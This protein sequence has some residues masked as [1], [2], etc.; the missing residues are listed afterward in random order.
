[1]KE[2]LFAGDVPSKVENASYQ[3]KG[4]VRRELRP[5]HARLVRT[6]SPQLLSH[7]GHARRRPGLRSLLR[8]ALPCKL[9]GRARS[10]D[11]PNA[12]HATAFKA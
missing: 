11:Q 8:I 6:A 2:R 12:A 7:L 1:M 5:V 10:K 3:I 4:H 9:P